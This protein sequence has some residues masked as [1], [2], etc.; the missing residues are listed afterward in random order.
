VTRVL[1]VAVKLFFV[2]IMTRRYGAFLRRFWV[3]LLPL[4]LAWRQYLVPAKPQAFGSL[5]DSL[6]RQRRPATAVTAEMSFARLGD[7]FA[8]SGE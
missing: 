3:Y 2:R 6:R 4:V 8:A 7:C 5:S 1:D